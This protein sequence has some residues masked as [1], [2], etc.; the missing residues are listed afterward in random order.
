M[1]HYLVL[2]TNKQQG[3]IFFILLNKFVKHILLDFTVH[4]LEWEKWAWST[5]NWAGLDIISIRCN[6][7]HRNGFHPDLASASF[8]KFLISW[9][10]LFAI[11]KQ[12]LLFP[13][14][15]TKLNEQKGERLGKSSKLKENTGLVKFKIFT[16]L[17]KHMIHYMNNTIGGFNVKVADGGFTSRRLDCHI[18]YVVPEMLQ[19]LKNLNFNVRPQ[20]L[21]MCAWSEIKS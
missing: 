14:S 9:N 6:W 21:Q 20:I 13:L 17:L 7:R 11:W 12:Y 18:F 1:V 19:K 2:P 5:L 10:G 8:Y 15:R 3:A 4:I 16:I